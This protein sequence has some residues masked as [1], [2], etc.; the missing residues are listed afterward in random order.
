MSSEESIAPHLASTSTAVCISTT[1]VTSPAT[2]CA[3][4]SS[5]GAK[6]PPSIAF[7]LEILPVT[8]PELHSLV[9]LPVFLVAWLL[10]HFL[11]VPFDIEAY[12]LSKEVY[13]S[14][15]R[16]AGFSVIEWLDPTDH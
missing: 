8:T 16:E 4:T 12:I 9:Y 5:T 7:H 13:E 6:G 1:L 2:S 15:A 11:L 3:I 10:E 14:S